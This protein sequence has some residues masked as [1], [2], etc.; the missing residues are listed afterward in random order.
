MASRSVFGVSMYLDYGN[1]HGLSSIL[2]PGYVLW[3]D[4][5]RGRG[6]LTRDFGA[7]K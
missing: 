3:F 5:V 4:V 2:L 7:K 6:G 1:T